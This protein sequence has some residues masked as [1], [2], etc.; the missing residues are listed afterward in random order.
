MNPLDRRIDPAVRQRLLGVAALVAVALGG[1]LHLLGR[2]AAGDGVWA[3][4]IAVML[5]PLMWS[6]ARTLARRDVGV[7]AIALV[8]MAGALALGEYLAGAVV[9]LMLAGGN[10]LEESASRRAQRELRAL[11]ERA[12]RIAHR[13]RGAVVEE[14]P[15][16]ELSSGDLVVMRAGEVVSVDGV[17]ESEG[18]VLDESALTGEPLPVS[19][20]RG[21]TVRSGSANAGDAFDLR[22]TRSASEST[23]AGIVRLVREA[24]R[25][26]APFVRLADRYAAFFL[27]VMLVTAGAAWAL[28]ANAA[29]MRSVIAALKAAGATDLKTQ[30]VSL[31][32]RYNEKSEPQGFVATN[33]VSA[34]IKELAKAG[35]VIDAA[36]NAGANQVYGPSLS[37]G[38]QAELY[39]QALKAAVENARSNAQVL[40]AAAN[41][42]LGRV[43]AIV[44]GGGAP[45][46]LP[47]AADKANALESMPIEAG[48]QNVS[49]TVSV[50]FSFS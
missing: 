18:A 48:T 47:Y 8:S 16:D 14:V 7:D 31:S 23:Y 43:T 34:T 44:E 17:V 42:S 15:V 4:S 50:T 38:D 21:H 49:A 26:R 36:V 33:S 30:S 9:A 29:E 5:V 12:P 40:A 25:H 45:Q 2:P 1:L 6:V 39:R 11:L 24:E 10:A 35:A 3:A 19:Y 22:A 46:P 32:P 37:R 13:R 28:S 20:E 41:L 27:P